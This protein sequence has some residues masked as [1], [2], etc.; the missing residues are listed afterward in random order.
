MARTVRDVHTGSASGAPQPGSGAPQPRLSA[1][2]ALR[3]HRAERLLRDGFAQRRG[4]VL[5]V[6]RS[7]LRASGVRLDP[8]DLEGCYSQAWHG[9]YERTLAGE[10]IEDPAAWLVLATF[11]RAI[12]EARSRAS[13]TAKAAAVA[14]V[15]GGADE[16]DLAAQLD[17][18]ERLRELFEALRSR[19][20]ERECEA[21][22]LCYLHGLTRDQA[23]ARMNIS[24]ARMRKLM[25]GRGAGEP[26]VAAK[27]GELVATIRAGG[28]CDQQSSL[29]RAYAF[30]I[31]DSDGERHALAVAHTRECPSCRAQVALM[32][33]L[34]VVLP[35]LPLL[36][37]L[38]GDHV[39]AGRRARR[40]S[41]RRARGGGPVRLVARPG[42]SALR[43]IATRAGERL[44]GAGGSLPAKLA[45][46]GVLLVGAG[47]A[48]LVARP[49]AS[50]AHSSAHSSAR[51]AAAARASLPGASATSGVRSLRGSVPVRKSGRHRPPRSSRRHFS[52]RH[53]RPPTRP[54][55]T[56]PLPAS[57]SE[58]SPERVSGAAT[59]APSSTPV[60]ALARSS[61]AA[62]G[63]EFG[64]EPGG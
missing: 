31:L 42:P 37:P 53:A 22:S 29:L 50:P 39:P 9:L 46:S 64:I 54:A 35:P 4:K 59:R 55:V 2:G 40:A 48:Y 19:L 17:D 12:D 38:G 3:R 61:A 28:W 24:Q 14:T 33:G 1:R 36:A 63:G 13:A 62:R 56:A 16:R 51:S 45:L 27:V 15:A 52:S 8:A 44:A 18:R 41:V 60:P 6:V 57:A 23:A 43:S 5:A 47:G 34:A 30:G 20:G 26:G 49:A 58:F 7:R 10:T 11:R 32:R 25:E 21:A